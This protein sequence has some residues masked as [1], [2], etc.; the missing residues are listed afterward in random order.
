MFDWLMRL[1]RVF[2]RQEAEGSSGKA[3]IL[4]ATES[5][6]HI[7]PAVPPVTV[8]WR[9]APAPVVIASDVRCPRNFAAR[10]QSVARLNP[11]SSRARPKPA[12][13]RTTKPRPVAC[14][15]QPKRTTETRSGVV[16]SRINRTSRTRSGA[17]IIDIAA[18]RRERRLE[19]ADFTSAALGSA[20]EGAS[21]SYAALRRSST[22]H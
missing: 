19:V 3:E 11:P 7:E 13:D 8:D 10:F 20:D 2:R 12:L 14:L 17:D 4:T 15:P 5:K 1:L 18:V 16:L 6:A 22:R 21:Q 9:A